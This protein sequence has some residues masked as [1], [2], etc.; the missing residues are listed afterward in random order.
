MTIGFIGAGN[1]AQA[2]AK[3]VISTGI[4]ISFYFVLFSFQVFY[5]SVLWVAMFLNRGRT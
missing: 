2:L 3:G 1:M 5:Y 4:S